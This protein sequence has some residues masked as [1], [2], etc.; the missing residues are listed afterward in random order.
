MTFKGPCWR[1]HRSST[2]FFSFTRS[3][4]ES[5]YSN[6]FFSRKFCKFNFIPFTDAGWK[7]LRAI[8]MWYEWIISKSSS[9][10]IVG[11]W[12]N[13]NLLQHSRYE[14][15]LILQRCITNTFAFIALIFIQ[16]QYL[17]EMFFANI[18]CCEECMETERRR[19]YRHVELDA[20]LVRDYHQR[21]LPCFSSR[22]AISISLRRRGQPRI[23]FQFFS[24]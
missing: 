3:A 24:R 2:R 12:I 8:R 4:L 19:F 11:N 22:S 16:F 14:F 21:L 7:L 13:W 15:N 9:M 20:N 6:T 5:L 1:C 23:S 10:R 17:L 18:Y